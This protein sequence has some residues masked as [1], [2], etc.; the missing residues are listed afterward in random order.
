MGII[1]LLYIIIMGYNVERNSAT[2][3]IK[4]LKESKNKPKK[5]TPK[6]TLKQLFD[7]K[8]VKKK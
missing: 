6:K 1:I 8:K 3:F 2:K 4:E 7:I 5:K